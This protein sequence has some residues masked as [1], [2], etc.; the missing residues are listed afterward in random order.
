MAG[1]VCHQLQPQV[2]PRSFQPQQRSPPQWKWGET[3]VLS[4]WGHTHAPRALVIQRQQRHVAGRKGEYR[5]IA[6]KLHVAASLA[7]M[8]RG[9]GKCWLV[10]S[11]EGGKKINVHLSL[12]CKLQPHGHAYTCSCAISPCRPALVWEMERFGVISKEKSFANRDRQS[13]RQMSWD[14]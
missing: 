12:V 14:R 10:S 4:A 2:R 9:E 11:W 3:P 8:K 13:M 7:A 1:C 6:S 5:E